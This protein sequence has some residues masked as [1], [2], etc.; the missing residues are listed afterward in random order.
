MHRSN[1]H[2]KHESPKYGSFTV[3][4]CVEADAGCCV[5]GGEQTNCEEGDMRETHLLE[6]LKA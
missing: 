2:W 3:P 1:Y 6:S 5:G 4:E